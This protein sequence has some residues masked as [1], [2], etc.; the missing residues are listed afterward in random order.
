MNSAH[1]RAARRLWPILTVVVARRIN[2]YAGPPAGYLHQQPR[3]NRLGR[4][5]RDDCGR[6]ENLHP[7]EPTPG[8]LIV[9][10]HPK[11]SSPHGDFS[12]HLIARRNA[13][14]VAVEVRAAEWGGGRSNYPSYETYRSTAE[15]LLKPLLAAYNEAEGTRLRM[16]TTP[17]KRLEPKLPPWGDTLFRHFIAHA[18]IPNLH[19]HDWRRFYTFVRAS[20]RALT[21]NDV[22]F[23]LV[24]EG[25]P[26]ES[27]MG[28][29]SIYSHLRDFMR[30]SEAWETYERVELRC[31]FKAARAQVA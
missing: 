9:A 30:A 22:A 2:Q 27:A 17:K 28:I 6:F 12:V 15:T 23:L 4:K 11:Q 7:D 25:F 24:K 3:S 20:S 5:N 19:P 1:R 13:R 10:L 14:T 16:T 21:A 18:N 31:R 26:E 29:A 8:D